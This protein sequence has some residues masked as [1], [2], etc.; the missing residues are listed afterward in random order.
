MASTTAQARTPREAHAEGDDA[1]DRPAPK[2]RMLGIDVLR[3]L[4]ILGMVWLHFTLTGWG[5]PAPPGQPA[6]SSLNWINGLL[7]TRSREI[8][9]LLAGVTVAL[10]TGGTSVRRGRE[11]VTAWKRVTVRAG[12]LFVLALVLGELGVWELQILHYYALWLLLLLPLSVLRVRTLLIIAGVLAVACPVFKIAADHAG[13]SWGFL[14]GMSPGML[15][16]ESVGGFALLIHPGEWLPTL[17]NVI[18][19]LGN[20][21]QDTLSVLPFLTLGLAL[22][23]LDLRAAAVRRRMMVAGAGTAVAAL[24]LSLVSMYPLGAV[25]TV[26]AYKNPPAAA[27]AAPGSAPSAPPKLPKAPWESLVTMGHPGPADKQ[28]SATEGTFML[29][30]ITALLGGLLTLM[31]KRLWRRLLRPVA[32]FGSMALTWYFGHFLWLNYLAP[33]KAAEGGTAGRSFLSFA[34][35]AVVSLTVSLLWRK[36]LRRGPLEWLVHQAVTVAV[37]GRRHRAGRSR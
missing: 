23:K 30:T 32:A 27:T 29:G 4:A 9:F 13:A 16:K 18:F 37:P 34:V 1:T 2:G 36:W 3:A 26:N 21:G 19:G 24:L 22:G 11:R 28:F 14:P 10:L 15:P 12:M 8:F 5:S 33:V 31:D 20:T 7:G 35:F 6:D 17:Q 25:E